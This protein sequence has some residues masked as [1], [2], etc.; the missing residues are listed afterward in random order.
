MPGLLAATRAIR[1][2]TNGRPT[3]PV[4]SS[5][6]V[7]FLRLLLRKIRGK[8]LIIWDGALSHRGQPSQEFL[9]RGAGK[10]IHLEQLPGYAPDRNPVAGIGNSLQ[11]REVGNVCCT[12]FPEL[13]LA[14][15]RAKERL[16]H[17]PHV[18]LGC[19]MEC[20]YHVYLALYTDISSC[21]SGA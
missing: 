8:F 12:G 1:R 16:R 4:V 19:S 3:G 17:K 15:R 6:V 10:R 20:G 9:V 18:L 5:E 14:L 7:R 2:K 13:D 21:R 11:C